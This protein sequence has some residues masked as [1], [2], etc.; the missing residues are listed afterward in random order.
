MKC[1]VNVETNRPPELS[2]SNYGEQP[3]VVFKVMINKLTR[4]D[5]H[6]IMILSC[7]TQLKWQNTMQTINSVSSTSDISLAT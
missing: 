3:R 6:W 7:I 4:E 5:Q 1:H 2:F